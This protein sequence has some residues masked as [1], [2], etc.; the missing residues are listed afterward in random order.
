MDP[1]PHLG[2]ILL[3]DPPDLD[4]ENINTYCTYCI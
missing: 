1:D 4:P 2:G 3:K